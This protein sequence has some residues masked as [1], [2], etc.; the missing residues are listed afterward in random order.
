VSQ[1]EQVIVNLVVNARDAMPNGGTITL[2]TSRVESTGGDVAPGSY[3]MIEVADTGTGI[4]DSTKRQMFEPFFTS[5][6]TGRG[7]GLGLSTS[8]G[9]VQQCGGAIVVESELG[10][11]TTMKVLL[12]YLANSTT[13]AAQVQPRSERGSETVLLIED[14]QALRGALQRVLVERGF[15]V[16]AAAGLDAAIAAVQAHP[17]PVQLIVSDVVMPHASGPEVVAQLASYAPNA[18]VL[19]ISGFP[20]HTSIERLAM[21][22]AFLHKPFTPDALVAKVRAVLAVEQPCG[23]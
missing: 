6:P 7:T 1:L 12:P 17:R 3:V 16:V 2:K 5:K 20:D 18:R 8:Y 21:G 4:D 23:S 22:V 10:V 11:G 15:D 13:V 9:I 14:N 19:F